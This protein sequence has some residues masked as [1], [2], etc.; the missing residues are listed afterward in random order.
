MCLQL[1]IESQ[2][3][4]AN[5][6]CSYFLFLS[7]NKYL[8]LLWSFW[9][10]SHSYRRQNLWIGV[11]STG[12]TCFARF[13]TFSWVFFQFVFCMFGN[14]QSSISQD[15]QHQSAGKQTDKV[16]VVD[17]ERSIN[18]ETV[19]VPVDWYQV[20]FFLQSFSSVITFSWC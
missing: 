14:L 17:E 12:I 8:A 2:P 16:R 7:L 1:R 3:A 11:L 9:Y 13:I 18:L 4:F 20:D 19:S 5:C 10:T 15:F 6:L